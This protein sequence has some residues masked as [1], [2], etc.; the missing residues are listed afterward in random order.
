MYRVNLDVINKIICIEVS[1]SMSLKEI[2]NLVVDIDDLV[3]K[4]HQG[5][6]SMLIKAQRL[7]PIS[8]E[9]I[10]AFQQ[11]MEIAL[12]WANEVVIVYGNRTVTRM[13]L[14]RMETDARTKT[15]SNT[16]IVI[17]HVMNEAINYLNRI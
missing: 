14:S 7:D 9:N 16:P 6:Y 17:F 3:T 4:F 12:K 2:N 11:V 15:N 5:Q 10:P 1:G 8:Q 13:Q